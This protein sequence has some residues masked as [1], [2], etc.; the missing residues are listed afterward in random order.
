M[1]TVSFTPEIAPA[2]D[3]MDATQPD[4]VRKSGRVPLT[5]DMTVAEG[6][7]TILATCVRHLRSN[8]AA[9]IER[10]DPAALHQ[11]R[12]ALRRLRAAMALFRTAIDDDQ[13][14]RMRTEL[15]RTTHELADARDLDVLLDRPLPSE[16]RDTLI[17]RRD[18]A[19]DR[20]VAAIAAPG[21][22]ALLL[23]LLDWAALGEWRMR[24]KATRLL[25]PYV[26]LR[27]GRAWRRV[28]AAAHPSRMD[29][30]ERHRLRIRVKKLR[31]ALQFVRVL[32]RRPR[33]PRKIFARTVEQ[34]QEA[35]GR[36]NDAAMA[37]AFLVAH[38]LPIDLG[39]RREKRELLHG[40]D[41]ALERLRKIGRYWR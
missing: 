21:F 11:V 2:K 31:Y 34:L 36:L 3:P 30:G 12:V 23:D 4:C 26:E 38:N 16:Q 15:R 10:R 33:K 14:D 22:H 17:E 7:Q 1:N 6:F 29:D 25:R 8:E 35:L 28:K 40:A 5:T 32:H 41:D 39:E 27:I 18:R 20:A 19:Y 24:A 9:V 13:F 37:R